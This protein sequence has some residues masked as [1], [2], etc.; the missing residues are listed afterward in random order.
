LSIDEK[1]DEAFLTE[2]SEPLMDKRRR[3]ALLKEYSEVSNNFRMLT[4]A[5]FKLLAFLPIASAAAVAAL[6]VA[7]LSKGS[8]EG[9]GL[10]IGLTLSLFGLV[11]TIG[12]VTYNARNDQ[13]YFN[14][15][16]R[17]AAIERSL[18]I[19][20][21]A[22]SN[23]PGSWQRINLP[24]WLRIKLPGTER[25]IG[26]PEEWEIDH[27]TAVSAIYGTSIALWLFGVVAFVLEGC[28]RVYVDAGLPSVSVKDPSAWLSLA[29]LVLA[30][31]ATFWGSRRIKDQKE[32]RREK[33]ECLAM[34]AMNKAAGLSVSKAADDQN[35]I[36]ICA[37]LSEGGAKGKK[38]EV[39]TRANFYKNLGSKRLRTSANR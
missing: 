36:E 1:R 29:A 16:D 14:L 12:L 39:Q 3:E 2:Y 38:D 9:I 13:L 8:L 28:N 11:A 20:D 15:V 17:A 26:L 19:P 25:K 22:F 23:R 35:F 4:E 24:R 5:R 6:K 21:G 34:C 37:K 31:I 7:A 27:R 32:K 30:I 10:A 33:M 18:N